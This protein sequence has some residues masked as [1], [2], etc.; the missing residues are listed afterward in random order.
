MKSFRCGDIVPGCGA[1]FRAT[2]DEE[3]FGMIRDHARDEHGMDP[4][5]APVLEQVRA[6]VVEVD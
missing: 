5:P 3:L 1:S 6:R 2:S 4:V